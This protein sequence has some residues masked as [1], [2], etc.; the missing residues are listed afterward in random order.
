MAVRGYQDRRPGLAALRQAIQQKQFDTFLV[1][2][3]SRLFRR[4]Y[5]A[6]QFVE[7]QLV[8]KGIRAIFVKSGIDTADGDKWRT[9]FQFFAALDEAVV[10]MYGAHVRA[11][12]EGLF[13]RGLVCTSLPLGY[14]GEEVPGEF[15]KRKL[16]R[17]R[18]IVDPETSPWIEKIFS[19]F[20]VDRLGLGEIARLLNDDDNAPAPAKSLTGL[21]TH[22]LVRRHIMN[23]CYRGFWSYGVAETKW[24]QRQGLRPAFHPSGA[25]EVWAIRRAAD[26]V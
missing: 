18:I 8:E 10:R 25:V 21:W 14:T 16:P 19:W 15:T 9:T 4:T 11:A 2:A 24:S 17:R 6:L 13:L 20:V 22:A 23:P 26:R 7:E 5:K 12:H 1:F 3:T